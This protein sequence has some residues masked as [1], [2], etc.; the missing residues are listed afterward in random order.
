[1]SSGDLTEKQDAAA[2]MKRR[3]Q[4]YV[5]IIENLLNSDTVSNNYANDYQNIINSN[6][7]RLSHLLIIYKK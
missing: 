6:I 5:N 3:S 4:N 2:E 7:W 1:M